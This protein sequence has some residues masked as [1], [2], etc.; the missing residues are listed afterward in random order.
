ML[1]HEDKEQFGNLIIA[2]FEKTGIRRELVE[3]DY[4]VTLFL[5][6]LTEKI[7][8][9]IFKGGTSL[10][11][12]FHIIERFSEDIDVNVEQADELTEGGHRRFKQDVVTAIEELGLVFVNPENT[13]SRRD[14]NK[15]IIDYKPLFGGGV[16]VK[17]HLI[18]ESVFRIKCFPTAEMDAASL[19]YDYLKENGHDGVIERYELKPF[20][21][22]VQSLERT[23]I[24]KLFAVCDYYISGRI[25]EHSRHFY[26]LHKIYPRIKIDKRMR[27]LFEEVRRAREESDAACPSADKG[28]SVPK[29]LK[30]IIEKEIYR[31]DYE[32]KTAMLLYESVSYGDTVRSLNKIVS[33]LEG[34]AEI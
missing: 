27:E 28:V 30:E 22:T 16:S 14:Y 18:V 32:H 10:S 23:F 24:D 13:R 21:V 6:R 7:P 29:L 11:K 25:E 4:Y 8:T 20:P 34:D 9:L 3:K 31:R 17:Q 26:D 15:Y 5:K 12:C 1:L 2:V 19:I 33:E